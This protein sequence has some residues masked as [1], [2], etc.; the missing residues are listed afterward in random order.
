VTVTEIGSLLD[1]AP[2][3]FLSF[4]DDGRVVLA[5]ATL[6]ERLGATR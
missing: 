1:R 4:G 6:L 2:G 3:F 5:N